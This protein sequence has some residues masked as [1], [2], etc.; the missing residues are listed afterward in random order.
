MTIG[1]YILYWDKHNEV[2]IGQST[3]IENRISVHTSAVKQNKHYN[4]KI[5]DL[6]NSKLIY[7]YNI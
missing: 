7:N 2:Y 1:I 5:Q 3:D 4:Y 6:Y